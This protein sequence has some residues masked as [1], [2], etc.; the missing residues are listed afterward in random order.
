MCPDV[1]PDGGC[2]PLRLP[3]WHQVVRLLN[4]LI[5]S[6]YHESGPPYM[7]LWPKGTAGF[8]MVRSDTYNHVIT[9]ASNAQWSL[10]CQLTAGCPVCRVPLASQHGQPLCAP[11]QSGYTAGAPSVQVNVGFG[12]IVVS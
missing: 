3:A 7:P 8:S 6:G 2:C 12:R 5:G 4:A 9:S 10:R 1:R 11:P